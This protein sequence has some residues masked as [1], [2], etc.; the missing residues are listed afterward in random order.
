LF[1]LCVSGFLGPVFSLELMMSRIE[2]LATTLSAVACPG[3]KPKEIISEVRRQHLKASKKDIVRGLLCA[4]RN[5]QAGR[6]Q[7]PGSA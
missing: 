1:R 5:R 4:D 7:E 3:M 2:K 6:E